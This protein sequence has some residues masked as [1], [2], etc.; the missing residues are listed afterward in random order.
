MRLNPS[1]LGIY[2]ENERFAEAEAA[3]AMDCIECGA[4][5]FACPTRRPLVQHLRR[6]KAEI[7]ANR[8]AAAAAAAAKK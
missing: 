1:D 6:A 8:R 4:C 2:I 7:A 3:S 5:A